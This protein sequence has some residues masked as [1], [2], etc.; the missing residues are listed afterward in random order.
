MRE[1]GEADSR[2]EAD[3]EAP[4]TVPTCHAGCWLWG[5]SLHAGLLRCSSLGH[6]AQRQPVYKT[7]EGRG[8]GGAGRRHAPRCGSQAPTGGR[9]VRPPAAARRPDARRTCRSILIRPYGTNY[10]FIICT[11]V[12][13]T[14]SVHVLVFCI[15][16][17][18]V[19]CTRLRVI[20]KP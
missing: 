5:A 6:P 11:Q 19:I 18:A 16:N 12:R 8:G 13:M 15:H 10:G 14:K 20:M 1:A 17:E 7:A 4:V 3:H 9:P 2:A